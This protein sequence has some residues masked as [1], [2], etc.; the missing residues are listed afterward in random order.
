MAAMPNN[1]PNNISMVTTTAIEFLNFSF[2]LKKIVIGLPINETTP[3][4]A[5]YT[6]TELI[7]NKK[8]NNKAIPIMMPK[9]LNMPL[10]IS[11]V[12]GEF[13]RIFINS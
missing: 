11:F 4:I 1:I 9:A 6:N 2:R 7:L 12:C 5:M 3:E 8:S 10:L 13:N